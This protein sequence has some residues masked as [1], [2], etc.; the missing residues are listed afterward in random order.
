MTGRRRSWLVESTVWTTQAD[1]SPSPGH[2]KE[3]PTERYTQFSQASSS[4]QQQSGT[5]TWTSLLA[6]EVPSTEAA[7]HHDTEWPEL[8]HV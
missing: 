5:P 8:L 7:H 6:G 2:G 3:S 4:R 1:L